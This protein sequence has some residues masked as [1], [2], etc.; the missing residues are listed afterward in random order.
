MR[1]SIGSIRGCAR[2][3]PRRNFPSELLLRNA[4]S[5]VHAKGGSSLLGEDHRSTAA[6]VQG[7]RR[8]GLVHGNLEISAGTQIS[9]GLAVVAS[10]KRVHE[11]RHLMGSHLKLNRTVAPR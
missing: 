2:R 5:N 9:N 4:K 3:W 8:A 1:G 6:Q 10:C 11:P 7:A